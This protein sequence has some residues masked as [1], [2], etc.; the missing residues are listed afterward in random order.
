[1]K[2]NYSFV[3]T[4]FATALVLSSCAV[5]KFIPEGEY[6]YRGGTI[7]LEDTIGIKNKTD[8]QL[9]LDNLLYPQANSKFLGLYPGLHY[10]YKGQQEKPGFINKFLNKK[11][12]E[13]P[14]YLSDVD[15]PST[16]EIIE[17]RLEN[18]GFF[19]SRITSAVERDSSAKTGKAIYEV[20]LSQ[21]YKM[22]TFTVEK[23][24][25][26]SLSLKLL[27]DIELSMGETLI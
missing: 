10:Y 11:F 20:T 19:S 15:V 16:E 14:V 9:E 4:T 21:P 5:K 8:L 25:V 13:E 6:L 2:I 26:D 23:D 1:M 12:G 18:N 27:E 17:N 24:S 7:K 3:L 22:E